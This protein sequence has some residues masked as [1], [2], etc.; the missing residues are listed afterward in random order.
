MG[1]EID[2]IMKQLSIRHR[3]RDTIMKDAVS[4]RLDKSLDTYDKDLTR[5]ASYVLQKN[6]LNVLKKL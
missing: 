3:T 5:G 6:E 4:C 2:R 1:N